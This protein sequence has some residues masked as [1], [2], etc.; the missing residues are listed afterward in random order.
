MNEKWYSFRF[1]HFS[2][3]L[4]IFAAEAFPHDRLLGITLIVLASVSA[5]Q[6]IERWKG[7]IFP[8]QQTKETK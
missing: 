2:G 4:I 1:R 6:M 8:E 7:I 3:M 5:N